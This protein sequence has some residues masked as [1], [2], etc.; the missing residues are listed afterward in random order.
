[1]NDWE[2]EYLSGWLDRLCRVI[3]DHRNTSHITSH[4]IKS[5]YMISRHEIQHHTWSRQTAFSH[6]MH[7]IITFLTP[8]HTQAHSVTSAVAILLILIFLG[9]FFSTAVTSPKSPKVRSE[10]L[11]DSRRDTRSSLRPKGIWERMGEEEDEDHNS[12]ISYMWYHDVIRRDDL[13]GDVILRYE[14]WFTRWES[15]TWR[16]YPY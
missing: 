7:S 1:M 3:L 15:F 6:F 14:M 8:H 2:Q 9:S 4:H 12:I 5:Y 10:D 13:K 16:R 11:Q